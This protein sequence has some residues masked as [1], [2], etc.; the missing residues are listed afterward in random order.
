MRLLPDQGL[1]RSGTA[2]LRDRGWGARHVGE[3]GMA[4]AEDERIL[5]YAVAE[6]HIC[7]TLDADFH[8]MLVVHGVRKPPVV[9]IRTQGM[10]GE[11]SPM[12]SNTLVSGLVRL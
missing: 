4:E 12:L 10:H 1:P 9:G 5:A 2:I 8:A 6:D 11:R 3:I 7:V